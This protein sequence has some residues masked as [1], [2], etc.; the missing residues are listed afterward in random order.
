MPVDP[1]E[2]SRFLHRGFANPRK[3]INK[4]FSRD[5]LA[6]AGIAATQRPENLTFGDWLRLFDCS[7]PSRR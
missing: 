6:D 3:M 1:R 2:F 4:S 5:E 7:M